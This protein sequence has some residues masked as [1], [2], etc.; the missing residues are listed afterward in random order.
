MP[1]CSCRNLHSQPSSLRL[2]FNSISLRHP[3]PTLSRLTSSR[4]N[5]KSQ[6]TNNLIF[7]DGIT[8][9]EG[10]LSTVKYTCSLLQLRI[11]TRKH[12]DVPRLI[13]F[14]TLPSSVYLNSK[15]IKKIGV[16]SDSQTAPREVFFFWEFIVFRQNI[17]TVPLFPFKIHLN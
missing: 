2:E 17:R 11:Y 5:L 4:A 7:W 16:R 15:Q 12:L 8:T 9:T 13:L 1:G 3:A 14:R 6:K 10:F